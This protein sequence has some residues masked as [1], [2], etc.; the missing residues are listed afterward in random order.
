MEK[1]GVYWCNVYGNH[2][3]EVYSYHSRKA[4][5][6]SVYG[7]K[8]KY[9]H[10]LFQ[11]GPE[12]ADGEGNY[13][14]NI[15]NPDG[16]ITQSLFMFDSHSYVDGDYFGFLWKYDAVHENQV[17]WYKN[18][19]AALTEENG[20][21]VPKSLAFFHIPLK[22]MKDATQE[23]RDNDFNDTENVKY[24]EGK[25]GESDMVVC[26]G[27]YNYGLFDAFKE[28]GSTQ[29]VFFGHD[30]L[31]N[32]SLEY[33][34]IRLT[35]GFSIDYLAYD[36]IYKYGL[37]RGCT[38]ITVAPDSSFDCSHQNYYQDKYQSI[39]EK[40]APILDHEMSEDYGSAGAMFDFQE[41][42]NK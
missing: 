32:M 13:V 30:H 39:N 5:S 24:I 16:V 37:Q 28:T 11:R 17:E 8:E 31:N 36:G 20:G 4:I 7:N 42:N 6:E 25:L 41:D 29:G 9:P 38:V 22:E 33:K 34:G 2:D 23:Y 40:D 15:K 10:C 27:L 12:E 1:L 14:I 3:T 18:T 26:S 35:Y 21:V 19:V